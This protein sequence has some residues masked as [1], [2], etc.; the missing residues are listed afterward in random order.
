MYSSSVLDLDTAEA[1]LLPKVMGVDDGTAAAPLPFTGVEKLPTGAVDACTKLPLVAVNKGFAGGARM[2]TA[3]WDALEEAP[4]MDVVGRLVPPP[5]RDTGATV[6][7][8]GLAAV[9]D[10]GFLFAN[11][12]C[13]GVKG[14]T[15]AGVVEAPVELE[16]AVLEPNSDFG[17]AP[18]VPKPNAAGAALAIGG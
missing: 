18:E 6:G 7:T 4:K 14:L 16:T 15:F 11:N 10:S 1:I 13:P 12:D 3:G 9:A 8:D 5:K 2:F 17:V